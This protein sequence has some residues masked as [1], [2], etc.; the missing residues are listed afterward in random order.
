MLKLN[1]VVETDPVTTQDANTAY[2]KVLD[3]A[4]CSKS[5]DEI[6]KRIVEEVRSRTATFTGLSEHNGYND[7]YPGSDINWKSKDYPKP[8]IIDSQNDLRPGDAGD[9]WSA[10]PELKS[11][12]KL[13]DSD[14]DG[15][16]DEWEKSKGLDPKAD[17]AN[18]RS[19]STAYDNIEV[20]INSLV[21]EITQKQKE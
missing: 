12:E 8:G 10:W 17:D 11:A 19:L 7:D 6:D 13:K 4:G 18:K 3:L 16:P 1:G 2:Q 14:N 21:E 9:G 5:R 15:M 20:Y